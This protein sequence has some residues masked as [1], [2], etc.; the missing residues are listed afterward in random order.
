MEFSRFPFDSHNCSVP[1]LAR[2]SNEDKSPEIDF[3]FNV[4]K[5]STNDDLEHP[6]WIVSHTGHKAT[7]FEIITDEG[8]FRHF[9]DFNW[10]VAIL[11]EFSRIFRTNA[12][13]K[14]H[15]P[16]EKKS[17]FVCIPY[18]YAESGSM[19]RLHFIGI[20]SLR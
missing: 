2:I 20:Y 8:N 5:Q 17:I 10:Y 7:T 16:I 11:L 9:L 14:L 12:C 15:H 4:T 13:F 1:I 3:F 6:D 18:V 19:F